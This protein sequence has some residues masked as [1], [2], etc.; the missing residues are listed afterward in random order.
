MSQPLEHASPPVQ[1]PKGA[2]GII[3]LIVFMDLL[4]FGVIIP[5][6][7]FYV[8]DHQQ[9]PVLVGLLFSIYSICQLF[10]APVLGALSDR[11]GRRPVLILSQIGSAV[12]YVLLG[13]VSLQE[14]R[15]STFGLVLIY[16]SRVIDGVSGG[17]VS[18][19]QAY[20]SDVT[21]PQTR[22]R[23]MG[24]LGAAFGLGFV[25]GPAL[26]GTL[27]HW[28]PAYPA[29]AAAA[30]SLGAAVLTYFKL[31]ESRVHKP[32]AAAEAWLH[33]RRFAAVARQPM[34]FQLL[35][36]GFVSMSAFVMMETVIA[37]FLSREDTFHFEELHV[38]F[39]FAF[40]GVIIITVQGGLIG[41]LTRIFGEWPLAI[42]G[43]VFVT[44]G[45]AG[46]AATAWHPVLPLLLLAG[47]FNACGRSFQHPTLSSLV[48]KYSRR[49]E[50]GVVFGM[51]HGLSSLARVIGPIVA[52]LAYA[53]HRTG[54]FVTAGVITAITAGWMLVL[55][56]S[57]KEAPEEPPV[58]AAV[59]PS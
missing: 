37:L 3:F 19:A 16:L 27:G 38:G 50:Q 42:A 31:P 49:D 57:T 47:G 28:H 5:L 9:R 36:V 23:G 15:V 24:I 39:F 59:E 35:L 6:L 18:T 44:I 1:P 41:R 34:L 48:S 53:Q 7:P 55:R 58:P 8:P 32:D 51:Y 21:T 17:N 26:G 43:P 2:L 29:F 30:F 13:W 22:A 52:T 46:F 33:P 12:G 40:I 45:M 56:F 20:I 54:A 4:G 10:A 25:A 14:W 11:F